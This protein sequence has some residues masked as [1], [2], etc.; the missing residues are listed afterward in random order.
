[1]MAGGVSAAA[2]I[3][4]ICGTGRQ[5][6]LRQRPRVR[7]HGGNATSHQCARRCVR[8]LRAGRSGPDEV[9]VKVINRTQAPDE[10]A[11]VDCV[12]N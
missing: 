3:R 5:H 10:R 9:P 11:E 1:M 8:A 4:V 7:S 2:K 6:G 12:P